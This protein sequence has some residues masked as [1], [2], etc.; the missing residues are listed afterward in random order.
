MDRIR[1]NY[2]FNPD[3]KNPNGIKTAQE[4]EW[5]CHICHG[6]NAAKFRV[7]FTVLESNRHGSTTRMRDH[8]MKAHSLTQT[9]HD[10]RIAGYHRGQNMLSYSET[11]GWSGTTKIQQ[12]RLTAR[13]AT[14]RW[15]VKNRQPFSAVESTEFQE[16]F[17]A[18][19]V[20]CAYKSRHTLRNHIYEDFIGRRNALKMELAVN[21]VSISF[22][23]DMWTYPSRKQFLQ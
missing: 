23:L 16:M 15:F 20:Q 14:R 17:M 3:T 6:K 11:N 9:T 13:Q 4:Y 2:L 12:H 21:C 18:H 22:T 5:R 7:K 8:L 10:G 19:N 1:K